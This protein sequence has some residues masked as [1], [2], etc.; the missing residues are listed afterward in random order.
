MRER[1]PEEGSPWGFWAQ[2]TLQKGKEEDIWLVSLHRFSE[3]RRCRMSKYSAVMHEL[4]EINLCL[5]NLDEAPKAQIKAI[6]RM[7]LFIQLTQTQHLAPQSEGA[8]AQ[9]GIRQEWGYICSLMHLSACGFC[10]SGGNLLQECAVGSAE[11]SS[12]PWVFNSHERSSSRCSKRA[13]FPPSCKPTV[14][15]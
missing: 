11:R 1:I 9:A 4:A 8:W 14:V 15:P 3:G 7:K 10:G 13:A 12:H 2:G 6:M 5:R